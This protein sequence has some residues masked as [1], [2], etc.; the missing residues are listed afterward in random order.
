MEDGLALA[1]RIEGDKAPHLIPSP[2]PLS[3]M[4]GAE[5]KR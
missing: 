3:T 4:E 2:H 5:R 1:G